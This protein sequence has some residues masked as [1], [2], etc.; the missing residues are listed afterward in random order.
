MQYLL[1]ISVKKKV[2]SCT[3]Y[4][5]V[6]VT[7][8]TQIVYACLSV[9]VAYVITFIIIIINIIPVNESKW[10]SY[11][12]ALQ[13]VLKRLRYEWHP[14][15]SISISFCRSTCSAFTINECV[16]V[17]LSVCS[18]FCYRLLSL[19]LRLHVITYHLRLSTSACERVSVLLNS[20][21]QCTLN[22]RGKL[23][24]NKT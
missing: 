5:R 1:W 11:G 20:Y 17:C 24:N 6:N 3:A 13:A 8:Q 22:N 14:S 2:F 10:L 12:I 4:T 19:I 16:C 9:C 7:R 23:T 21:E 15:F 18:F